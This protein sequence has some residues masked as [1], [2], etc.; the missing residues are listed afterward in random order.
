MAVSLAVGV[1]G[2]G[3]GSCRG[4][5]RGT[6]RGR[7]RALPWT[8]VRGCF[9]GRVRGFVRQPFREFFRGDSGLPWYAVGT[10]VEVAMVSA[11]GFHG[12][13]LLA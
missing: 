7:P 10:A 2:R 8:K 6:I 4:C 3:R 5:F 11:M 1:R 13:P 12:V 9:R